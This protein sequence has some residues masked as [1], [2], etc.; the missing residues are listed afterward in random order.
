M[1]WLAD[2]RVTHGPDSLCEGCRP[3]DAPSA[4]GSTAPPA[5]ARSFGTV[6][7][8]LVIQPGTNRK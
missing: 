2:H 4:P 3:P 6:R 8:D 1:T 7:S 5:A